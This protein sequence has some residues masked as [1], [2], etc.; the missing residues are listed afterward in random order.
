M[1]V[2]FTPFGEQCL[3][4][5]HPEVRD[6]VITID[7]TID[8]KGAAGSY[9]IGARKV[10]EEKLDWLIT[11]SPSTRFGPSGGRDFIEYMKTLKDDYVLQSEVPT[12]WHFIA[13]SRLMFERIGIWDSSFAP[14]YFEDTDISRRILIAMEEDGKHRWKMFD[15][16]AWITMQ[17]YSARLAGINK[18]QDHLKKYF[19]KKWGGEPG[20]ETFTR[21]FNNPNNELSYCENI[22]L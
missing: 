22:K 1:P 6:H 14:C 8:N 12:G 15:T 16:D 20:H 13:W 9:N 18:S 19:T 10:L 21:P 4:T 2:T 7:N 17:G 11:L 3:E 5:L